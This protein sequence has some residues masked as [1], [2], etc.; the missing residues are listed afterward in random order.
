M[1]PIVASPEEHIEK[2]LSTPRENEGNILAWYE[3]RLGFIATTARLMLMP[4]DD[5]LAHR[6]DGIF[7]TVKYC[8]GRL[9]D[10][11]G[12]LDRM[13]RSSAGIYLSPPCGWE[14][15]RSIIIEVAAAGQEPLGMVRILLGRGPGGFGIDP[16]E[17]PLASLYVVAYRFTQPSEG[18]Y[19]RGLAGFRTSIPSKQ[20]YLARIKNANY[21][22]N[23]LMVR[24]GREKG[25]DIPFCFTE[26][27]HLAESAVA[28]ICLVDRH[29]TL[30]V[31]CLANT[32]AGTTLMRAID[33]LKHEREHSFRTVTEQ[34]ILEA[35]EVFILGTGPEC[36][37]VVS[38]EGTP[39]GS[40]KPG[41]VSASLRGLLQKTLY[42]TGTPIPGLG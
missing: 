37:A 10:L 35:Q 34:D 13:K 38:Y 19:A 2:L 8:G 14:E 12:H 29:G 26:E 30:V 22:P 24:E 32:L 4:L 41:P 18:W 20:G 40:G 1:L 36:A 6:G 42:A 3:H 27:G 21:L 17:C 25:A 39:I 16:K 33:L 31:P 7:E 9:Y 28:N 5:H 11:S 15:I 23:V